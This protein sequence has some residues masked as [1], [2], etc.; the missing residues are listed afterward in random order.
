M[1]EQT[2]I[3]LFRI[4]SVLSKVEPEPDLPTG[5]GSDQKVP[6]LT[7]SGSATLESHNIKH[8]EWVAWFCFWQTCWFSKVLQIVST[9]QYMQCW[10]RFIFWTPRHASLRHV[11]WSTHNASPR[12]FFEISSSFRVM[13]HKCSAL[14]NLFQ[15]R[16]TLTLLAVKLSP[17]RPA[18][19]FH[20]CCQPTSSL[21]T[22]RS[23]STPAVG[24]PPPSPT[25]GPGQCCGAGATWTGSGS[26]SGSRLRFRLRKKN[27]LHK[28]KEK[29]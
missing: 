1:L 28:F 15:R 25:S 6:T 14:W 21:P 2:K 13:R 27:L 23:S 9:Q 26:R 18:V 12:C 20:P 29:N 16:Y 3:I 7:G 11:V 24:Q 22:Q 8:V 17:L 4:S 5:S 19:I 10:A